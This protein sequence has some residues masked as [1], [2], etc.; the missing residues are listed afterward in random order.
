MDYNSIFPMSETNSSPSIANLQPL[1]DDDMRSRLSTQ[2]P[3][4]PKYDQMTLDDLRT[5]ESVHGHD[6][7]DAGAI[8]QAQIAEKAKAYSKSAFHTAMVKQWQNSKFRK[9]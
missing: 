5:L 9:Q 7:I 8:A 2:S 1:T 6:P 4:P 3:T